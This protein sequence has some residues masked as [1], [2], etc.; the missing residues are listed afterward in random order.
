MIAIAYTLGMVPVLKRKGVANTLKWPQGR[1]M[2]K[3]NILLGQSNLLAP[4]VMY[5]S[6]T[7]IDLI[8]FL[9]FRGIGTDF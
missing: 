8:F 6:S 9:L 1:I 5:T 4:M 2:D 7:W 3:G